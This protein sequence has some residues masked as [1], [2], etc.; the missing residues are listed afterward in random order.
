MQYNLD[1]SA[2]PSL[3]I[4]D[5]I[6]VSIF[7][8][9]NNTAILGTAA[10]EL[11]NSSNGELT[12]IINSGDFKGSLDQSHMLYGIQGIKANRVLML[13]CG[14]KTSF[15]A[16]T[17]NKVIKS[18]SKYLKTNNIENLCLYLLDDADENTALKSIIQ[19][20]IAH[21][22]QKYQLLDYK[23]AIKDESPL[24]SVSIAFT[25]INKFNK[26]DLTIAINHG[27]AIV[28]GMNLAK[29]L[30]NHPGNICT[31]TYLAE[32][33]KQIASDY[34]NIEIHILEEEDM[35]ALGMGS[36]LSVSK[37]SDEPGKMITL[38]YKHLIQAE[39]H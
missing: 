3:N 15:D 33:A 5:C 17:A 35:K 23:S 6:V 30:A 21:G 24:K 11:D 26:N 18:A 29:D 25:D 12:K 27:R 20:I 8:D 2:S 13:G 32:Q 7:S 4:S 34:N 10:Q 36:F 28:D 9:K 1:T 22:D 31:P 37:G 14:E 38:E 39:Y 19:M 16:N